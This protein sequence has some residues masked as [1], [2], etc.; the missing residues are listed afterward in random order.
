MYL[1]LTVVTDW[2]LVH[3]RLLFFRS[4]RPFEK[5]VVP[6]ST[7]QP[8]GQNVYLKKQKKNKQTWFKTIV[9]MATSQE[10]KP[11]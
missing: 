8:N 5:L 1:S 3:L 10:T 4:S 9:L 7:S 2:L 11:N 6:S